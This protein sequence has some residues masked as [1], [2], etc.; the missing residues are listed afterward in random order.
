MQVG[1]KV[2]TPETWALGPKNIKNT[3]T[4]KYL[5]DIITNDGK[6][7]CNIEARF[8]RT[9]GIIRQINTTAG[10]E[11]MRKIETKT[12]L[13]LYD[14]CVIPSFLNNSESWT[15]S[16]SEENELDK[17]G[18]RILKRLFN[19]PEKTPS[20]AIIHSFGTLYITQ[21]IDQMKFMYYLG[22]KFGDTF[23]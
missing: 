10:S 3:T 1:R 12:I 4:Y 11:I 6:H 21:Q 2:K 23:Y 16:T 20:P 18:I 5:G 19:L 13:Q 9:Q 17:L 14:T 7:K 15:L 22:K 8:N